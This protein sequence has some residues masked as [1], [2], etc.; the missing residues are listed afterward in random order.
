MTRPGLPLPPG[1][2][3]INP[4]P[5]RMATRAAE[6]ALA[7]LGGLAANSVTATAFVTNGEELAKET[8]NPRLGIVGGLSILGTTG[9]VKP[10]SHAAYRAS[11]MV[12][13]RAAKAQGLDRVVLATG[14]SSEREAAELLGGPEA[15]YILVGDYPGFTVRAAAEEGIPEIVMAA[16]FAKAYKLALGAER[17]RFNASP[18]NLAPLSRWAGELTG[19]KEL[20]VEIGQANTA[21]HALELLRA[22]GADKVIKEIGRRAGESIGTWAGDKARTGLVIFDPEGVIIYEELC[23]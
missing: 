9:I 7:P 18:M 20:A 1:E 14:S 12:S 22:A 16:K 3:A 21:R 5:R 23:R 6:E 15:G 13:L 11:I 8:L 19:S 17:T 4:G 2:P 10:Y